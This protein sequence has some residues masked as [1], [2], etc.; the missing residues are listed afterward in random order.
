MAKIVIAEEYRRV[1]RATRE[2]L[3][4]SRTTLEQAAKV[5][6]TYVKGVE[7][8]RRQ[9]TESAT[10]ARLLNALQHQAEH[11]QMPAKTTAGLLRTLKRVEQQGQK[12][13]KR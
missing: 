12:T 10:L 5:G 13:P 11:A 2:R 3:G 9:S 7:S 6:Q 8:G 1:I 4:L